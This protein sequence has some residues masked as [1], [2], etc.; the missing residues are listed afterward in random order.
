MSFISVKIINCKKASIRK[1]PYIPEA[2]EC[3]VGEK[4]KNE[5]IEINPNIISYD[6]TDKKFYR[7]RNPK[8]WI[9]SEL[10]DYTPKE[11]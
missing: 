1:L 4:N 8:G 6:W 2:D 11:G 9:L 10:V 5:T 3:I 7:T